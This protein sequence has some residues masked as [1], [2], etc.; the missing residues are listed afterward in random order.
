[1]KSDCQQLVKATNIQSVL[2]AFQAHVLEQ[3]GGKTE[4]ELWLERI[5]RMPKNQ[6]QLIGSGGFGKVYK[7]QESSSSER[8][9]AVKI[10]SGFG[11]LNEYED[12]VHALENEYRVVTQLGNHPRIIQF[13]AIVRDQKNFQIMIVMEYME[14]GSLADKLKDQKPLPDTSVLKYLLQ[15]VEGV[16]F[17]HKRK[18]TTAI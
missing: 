3:L 15:I 7:I 4:N 17:I 18:Y 6:L 13:F 11:G 16:G 14:G 12:Q 10:V 2:N 5:D 9:V 8:A 1:M